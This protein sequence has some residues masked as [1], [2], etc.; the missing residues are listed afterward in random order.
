MPIPYTVQV[1]HFSALP[2]PG[3]PGA[4]YFDE[5]DVSEFLEKL[6]DT[7]FRCG[8]KNNE[9]IMGILPQYC[10]KVTKSWVKRQS[11]WLKKD[12]DT[13]KEDFL[14]HFYDDDSEQ[15]RYTKTYLQSLAQVKRTMQDNIRSYLNEFDDISGRVHSKGEVSDV[16]RA[17]L[18]IQGLPQQLKEKII[19]RHS[20]KQLPRGT[21]ITYSEAYIAIRSYVREETDIQRILSTVESPPN[22][23]KSAQ[24]LHPPQTQHT[25]AARP[26]EYRQ[27][28]TIQ[29][30]RQDDQD[31]KL[32]E[33]QS[34][35]EALALKVQ[36]GRDMRNDVRYEPDR[37]GPSNGLGANP[38]P[39]C[40]TCGGAHF[41]RPDQCAAI[42]DMQGRGIMH[43]D[44]MNQMV[45]GTIEQPGPRLR[46]VPGQLNQQTFQAQ[47]DSWK[48]QGSYGATTQS[49]SNAVRAT[50]PVSTHPT[51]PNASQQPIYLSDTAT[52]LYPAP[53]RSVTATLLGTAPA[54]ERLEES[55]DEEAIIPYGA[56]NAIEGRPVKRR[57][58]QDIA[59]TRNSQTGRYQPHV[60][61]ADDDVMQD[62]QP[63]ETQTVRPQREAVQL[64]N[65]APRRIRGPIDPDI[66]QRRSQLSDVVMRKIWDTEIT[67]TI[68]E[69]AGTA[70]R[71]RAGMGKGVSME[72]INQRIN[73]VLSQAQ[74][75]TN[76]TSASLPKQIE[77]KIGQIVRDAVEYHQ[78]TG[79]PIYVKD[80]AAKVNFQGVQL[81]GVQPVTSPREYSRDL[82]FV[83]VSVGGQVVRACI[84]IGSSV[85]IIRREIAHSMQAQMR[86]K[87]RLKLV[88]V[89]GGEFAVG[90]CIES[91]P[92]NVGDVVT[93]S[94]TMVGDGCTNDLL[95]GRIWAK[96]ALL[97][98][99]EKGDGRVI[100]T[101]SSHDRR[102][103]VS[104]E[105]YHPRNGG[106]FYE[107]QLW[108]STA[109]AI[110][111]LPL[112]A[113]SFV[114][115]IRLLAPSNVVNALIIKE[116]TS[117]TPRKDENNKIR[118]HGEKAGSTPL[119][120]RFSA[121]KPPPSRS[122]LS[123][124]HSAEP[125]RQ[126]TWS[127]T[128]HFDEVE[129]RTSFTAHNL[130]ANPK[131]WPSNVFR[132][133]N[134]VLLGAQVNTLYKRKADKIQPVNS[135]DSDGSIP[136]GNPDWQ[137]VCLEKYHSKYRA[138]DTPSEFDD[139]LRPRIATIARGARLTPEREESMLVGSGLLPKEKLL[140]RE[141][142]F[143]REGVLAWSW[144]HM[145]RIHEEVMP[146][147]RIKT[148]PHEAWQHPGFKIPRALGPVINDML[149]DRLRKGVLEPC[150]GPYRN[151]WFLV[152]KKSA[153]K[154]RLINAAMLINKV[155]KRDANMPPDADE[156]AEE[157]AGLALT[158]LVDLYSGY[159]Q[160][161]LAEEDR[162]LTAIQTPLGLLRQTTILQG[163]ANSVAQ[164]QRV[165]SWILQP[166]FGTIAR[167]FLDD[168]A[169]KGPRTRY[170]DEFAKPGIRKFVLEHLQNLDE[171]LYLLELAGAAVSA[172]KSQFAMSGI[173]VVGWICDIHGRRAEENKVAKLLDWPT[174][175]NKDE[176]RS[177][178]G[179]AVYFR[180]LVAGFQIIM[181]CLYACLRKNTPFQWGAK[182]QAAFDTV[183]ELLSS[184]PT[185]LP[186]DYAFQPLMIVVAVDASGKG[187]GAV[188][189]QER[190]GVRK[191][192]RY[193]SG[194]W[195]E[196]QLTY[197]AGKLECRAVLMALKKFR[198]WLYGIHFVLETDAKT[199]VSQLNRPATDLPGALV[200]RWMAW[201]RLFDF[202][203]KHVSGRKNGAADGLSRRPATKKEVQQQQQE[204]DVDDFID[205]EVSYLRASCFPARATITNGDE[206][207]ADNPATLPLENSYS[208]ESQD[209][210]RYLTTLR[211]PPEMSRS[212]FYYFK[213][214]CLKF[215]VQDSH[216]FYRHKGKT[217]I[218]RRV[219]D[220]KEDQQKAL[221]GAHTELSHKGREATYAL[222]KLRYYW[223]RMFEDTV[224]F[225]RTCVECQARDPTRMHEPAVASKNLRLFDKWFIDTTRMP[226]ENGVKSVVQGRDS[227]SGWVEARVLVS[228]DSEAIQ[229]FIHEDI[230]CRHGYPR[231][232][233]MDDGP[234]NRS[235]TL[236]FLE[237]RGVKKV[238]IS[239]YHPGSNGPVERAMRT[240]K[241][242]LSKMTGGYPTGDI[243]TPKNRWRPHFHA[244]LMAD[245]VTV[246]A[247]TGISPYYFLFGI[248]AVLPVELEIPTWSTLPWETVQDRSSLIAMRA[249]QI[250]RREKDIEEAILRMNRLKE[251]NAGYFD[252]HHRT[253]DASL[254]KDDYVLLHD[255]Q[256]SSDMTSIQKLRFRWLGP[257]QI[258][259]VKGNG[260][261]S[262]RELDGTVLRHVG[263]KNAD[264]INGDR[265]KRFYPRGIGDS[266]EIQ[267]VAQT[268]QLR[269]RRPIGRPR[270]GQ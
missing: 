232:I 104:F 155:T 64:H 7:C 23:S 268:G 252:D 138:T 109:T 53:V 67:L 41:S 59:R 117:K 216:L 88:P 72:V 71:I 242:A 154:Y 251:N 85:N 270:A 253:R 77:D 215:V 240:L 125:H 55:E 81:S 123:V 247:T 208:T 136:A 26:Q 241:D 157:F 263:D 226:D 19:R 126:Y 20:R 129:Y 237:D 5:T 38:P 50:I 182:Q 69:L 44:A 191:P 70:P 221:H 165:V 159:D 144:E 80:L 105:A 84:D 25:T 108:Y 214:K 261:Y 34:Q 239:A 131:Q 18:L 137:N 223:S 184:F 39:R 213:R 163:A 172:E 199:L 158:S 229:A 116:E 258:E 259:S 235:K 60:E 48:N 62:E 61:D 203:V 166:I 94:H 189:M 17:S 56:V 115:S 89:D 133:K 267:S 254:K 111:A 219:L 14:E 256:R 27:P 243:S 150:D 186:I 228:A 98:T 134:Q 180:I 102:K 160:I 164:F 220:K 200:T 63:E 209:I 86:L 92:I 57:R 90:A 212:H 156:F 192:A 99:S 78:E 36:A 168:V 149:R 142:L 231:E 124:W 162:D 103:R 193:E 28:I 257:Y 6:Q 29:S 153:G 179:L 107:D 185:V 83:T 140:L 201:I 218:M 74:A 96:D 110:P 33:M 93:E 195:T 264:A 265:L 122:A 66:V 100:C 97:Q 207:L 171:T 2:A 68:G 181:D 113:K 202:D 52:D 151:P 169:I 79:S 91:L 175:L 146:A 127:S 75:Q 262:I 87:P 31:R 196:T 174:P 244:A 11:S 13:F 30:Q 58:D 178:V 101:I 15:Q 217:E 32:K 121:E 119:G 230:I 42:R 250:E 206:E 4:P 147:Q 197:D 170:N 224:T 47:Y 210:A 54:W 76:F 198:H 22:S 227:V 249:R 148:I 246:N 194:A 236:K 190:D 222:L 118:R 112:A 260:S 233:V 51:D 269:K 73:E 95:L 177:F 225:V 143:K 8:V 255:S 106:S 128:T 245:R 114:Q 120:D 204:V 167:S 188:L 35:M 141:L 145:S 211:R 49:G 266:S 238:T 24:Q 132:P 65:H 37:R 139:L 183:K 10:A 3:S 43:Y 161:S 205:A 40:W 130:L 234:E 45:L 248:H 152:K 21:L 176:L 12:W 9:D 187:W 82:L 173:E 1:P 16:D 46:V 135:S